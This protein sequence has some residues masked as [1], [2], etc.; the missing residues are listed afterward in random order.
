M[1]GIVGSVSERN[2]VPMILDGLQRLEYRGYDSVGIAL[3]DKQRHISCKRTVGRVK[4]LMAECISSDFSGL[5]GIGHTRW[6][7]H[8]AVENKNTH[9]H[10]SRDTLALVHNGIIENY[11]T[12]REQLIAKGYTFDSDTD[13]EVIVH[14]IHSFYINE[15]NLFSA[16]RMAIVQLKG[17]FAIGI[18]DKNNPQQLVCA[19]FG[20]PLL[21]G[22]GTNEMFFASDISALLPVTQKVVYLEDGDIAILT[23]SDFNVYDKSGASLERAISVTELRLSQTELGN[24]RHYMQKEIFEQPVAIM[25]TLQSLGTQFNANIF[26][27]EALNIFSQIDKVQ[28]I[29]CGTSYNAGMI[30]KY[31]IEELA[32]LPCNVDIASEYRYRKLP[33]IS[34]TLI[35]AISQSGETADTLACVR[36]MHDLG[37]DN[38]LA[39][40]NVPA[41]TLARISKLSILTKAGP[42][43]GVASTKAFTTQLLILLF[44]SN[45]LAK[46]KGRLTP[47]DEISRM[48]EMRKLP[49]LVANMFNLKDQL[50]EIA[51]E[52][53][54]KEHAL[55]LGRHTMYPTAIE[56]ALKLKEISYIHAEAYAAGELKHGPLALVDKEMPVFILMSKALLYEKLESNLQEVLARKGKVYLL[57]DKSTD[58]LVSTCH[59]IIVLPTLDASVYVLPIL[60]TVVLQML[61]YYTAVSR[62]TDVDKPRNLA[63]SVTVE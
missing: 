32:G 62:G 23:K 47:S 37:M 19:C 50:E 8:G 42:E 29:A 22:V 48:N 14:L 45:A 43:I 1:C 35:V 44:L 57:T 7:T 24:Y 18:I 27:A 17:T 3:I 36:Y 49:H 12:L 16:V 38:T 15:R 34:Q 46:I 61:A 58:K 26:G 9:P 30:A 10:C 13:T 40:C 55:F 39:I 33:I 20:S 54:P 59:K 31:W 51:Y 41:S 63:K 4:S 52:L 11:V 53:E 25:Q 2:I 28:I 60:Y 21:L 6:A 56:G 5:C